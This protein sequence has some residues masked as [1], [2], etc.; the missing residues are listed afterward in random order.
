MKLIYM[1]QTLQLIAKAKG[2]EVAKAMEEMGT[3]EYL[4][5]VPYLVIKIEEENVVGLE[6]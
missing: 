2:V 5:D 4:E 1:E 3:I 6:N